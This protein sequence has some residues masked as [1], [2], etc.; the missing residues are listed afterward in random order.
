MSSA[1]KSPR[2]AWVALLVALAACKEALAWARKLPAATSP[3]AAYLACERGD[4][5]VWLLGALHTR[6]AVTRQTLVLA[7]CAAARTALVHLKGRLAE[8]A[9]L[10]SIETTERWCRGEAT[11]DD[12]RA[13]RD[14]AASGRA[15]AW[16]AYAAADAA[17]AADYAAAA[18]YAAADAAY[19]AA[20]AADAADAAAY[21]A[22]AADAAAYAADAVRAV[23]PWPV[24]DAA[25]AQVTL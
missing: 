13:A 8:A 18:A 19:A 24:V 12:V 15:K 14:A 5:L 9:A 21:A 25:L 23:V 22:D 2:S 16:A 6:E 11:L 1:P 3:E 20:A 7:V 17:Y 10:A 4:W